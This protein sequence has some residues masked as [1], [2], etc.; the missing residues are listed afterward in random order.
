MIRFHLDG[1]L[2]EALPSE[3]IWQVAKREGIDIPHLCYKPRA[4]LPPDGNCRACMVEIEGERVLVPPLQA[5]AGRRHEG[6]PRASAPARP[7]RMVMELLVADQPKRS[8]LA[9]SRVEILALGQT[10]SAS[11]RAA[12]PAAISAGT[13]D[14]ATR[15][16]RSIST[17]AS[18]AT[19]ASAPAARCR[20]TTSSAW[21]T[22]R[23]HSPRSCSTSTTRW[24]AATCVA[25]GECV[26][27]CP[28]GALMPSAYLDAE[29]KTRCGVPRPRGRQ[30]CAPIAASAAR[31]DLQGQGREVCLRRGQGTARPTTTGSA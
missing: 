10:T 7:A 14:A 12:S 9:R 23:H 19:S 11:P 25:C 27:A 29:H 22:A 28:T 5:H 4:R 18:S 20:S 13:G 8:D 6:G 30:R 16:E 24:A 1:K 21:P 3:T 2:V 17:P 31:S 26:Q 15:H